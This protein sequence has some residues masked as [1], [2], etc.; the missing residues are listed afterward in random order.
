MNILLVCEYWYGTGGWTYKPA[1]EALGCTVHVFDYRKR[2]ERE[3][4][5]PMPGPLRRRLDRRAMSAELLRTVGELR[6]DVVLLLKGETIR[7]DALREI[8]Q[9]YN[10]VLLQWYPD[11]PFNVENRNATSDSIASIPLFDIYYIYARSLMQ[12]LRDAGA[13]RVEYLPFCYDPNMLVMPKEVSEEDRAK[14]ATDVVFAGTWE[15]MREWWLEK[16]TDLPLAVW[17]NM[18]E[19]VAEDKPLRARW[20]ANAVY[21]E[22]ISKLFAVSKI[23]LNFLREQN[24]DSHNVRT[25]EIPG[26]GGFLLTQRSREQAEDLFIEGKEIACFETPEELRE[27]IRYY[28]EHEDERLAIAAAGHERAQ[29]EHQAIH[30]L[31]RIIDDVRALS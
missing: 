4:T 15:P 14:Y 3:H 25:L 22:E 17:G 19:R 9:R 8:K 29:R 5:L 27:K 31:Q 21:G 13:R 6:P 7:V 2:A 1:L 20:R 23:H 12:P 18:W 30:R 16:I 28:L 26:F 10:P 11:G 24:K